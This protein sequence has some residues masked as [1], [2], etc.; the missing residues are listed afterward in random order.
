VP[1][2]LESDHDDTDY[3]PSRTQRKEAAHEVQDLADALIALPEATLAKIPM[4]DSLR[5]AMREMRNIR[6]HEA[7]RRHSKYIGKLIR[8]MD[9]GPLRAAMDAIEASRQREARAHHGI[10]QWRERLLADDAALTAFV[11]EYRTSDLQALRSLIRSTRREIAALPVGG[12]PVTKGRYYR[13]LFRALR[14]AINAAA[15]PLS[16]TE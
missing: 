4:E 8:A 14:E 15:A 1:R 11:N 16:D 10:E 6:S 5:D 7:R 13:E 2:H 9:D 3:G 12:P